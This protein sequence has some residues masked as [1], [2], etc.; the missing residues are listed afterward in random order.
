[1]NRK[2]STRPLSKTRAAENS[3]KAYTKSNFNGIITRGVEP[4]RERAKTPNARQAKRKAS[5]QG[6]NSDINHMV[7]ESLKVDNNL[8]LVNKP[9]E[10]K[11]SISHKRARS[12]VSGG[13]R[14]KSKRNSEAKTTFWTDRRSLDKEIEINSNEI[15]DL[16][17]RLA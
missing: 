6:G 14:M 16:L 2:A 15:N 12:I 13:F 10:Q 5:N 17:T 3:F 8:I 4:K 9:Q 7:D 1:M 11:R